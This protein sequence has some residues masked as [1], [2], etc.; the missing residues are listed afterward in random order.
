MPSYASF[1]FTLH[2]Y[3]NDDLDLMFPFWLLKEKQLIIQRPHLQGFVHL[4]TRLTLLNLK[5]LINPNVH[6]EVTRGSNV[7]NENDCS[8][9]GDVIIR[10]GTPV[11]PSAVRSSNMSDRMMT[12]VNGTLTTPEAY[13]LSTDNPQLTMCF[14]LHFKAI[15]RLL[16]EK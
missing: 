3:S 8:K 11:I 1:C 15:E 10:I 6:L 14:E 13:V 2:N 16:T 9:D 12:I 5:R 4:K 7:E